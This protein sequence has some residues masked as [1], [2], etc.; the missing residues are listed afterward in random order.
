MGPAAPVPW[1]AC[2][3]L[4]TRPALPLTLPALHRGARHCRTTAGTGV[5]TAQTP[6]YLPLC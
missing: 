3:S 2:N 1:H 6:P 4:D 5:D